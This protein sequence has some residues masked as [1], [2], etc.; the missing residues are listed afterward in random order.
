MNIKK[1]IWL[2]IITSLVGCGGTGGELDNAISLSRDGLS[3]IEQSKSEKL[4]ATERENILKNGNEKLNQSKE[5]YKTLISDEPEN[6]VYLNNY[7]WVQMKSGDLAGA[8]KSFNQA[9][10]YKNSLNP[11]DSLDKN[12]AEL[13]RLMNK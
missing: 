12:M 9:S 13:I 3:L 2:F 6:G 5:I 7:G 10:K 8:K 1:V 11:E 4:E